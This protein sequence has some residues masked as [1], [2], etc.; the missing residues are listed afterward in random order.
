MRSNIMQDNGVFRLELKLEDV[1]TI[2]D[3]TASTDFFMLMKLMLQKNL[4]L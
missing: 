1:K 2:R 3:I 4:Q